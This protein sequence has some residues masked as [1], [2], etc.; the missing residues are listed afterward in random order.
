MANTIN[1]VYPYGIYNT[2]IHSNFQKAPVEPVEA[3]KKV[4]NTA[5]A[6]TSNRTYTQTFDETSRIFLNQYTNQYHQLQ[7][8]AD[9]LRQDSNNNIWRT[10]ASD[11]P[12]T[13]LYPLAAEQSYPAAV[14]VAQ[15][16]DKLVAAH[17]QTLTLLNEHSELG[18]GLARQIDQLRQ[19]VAS[20]ERM[21]SIGL[22]YQESGQ[23]SFDREAF[24]RAYVADQQQV[25]SLLGGNQGIAEAMAKNSADALNQPSQALTG[26]AA[27]SRTDSQSMQNRQNQLFQLT[28][29]L[30]RGG[31][32]AVSFSYLG[33]FIDTHA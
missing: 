26:A 23:L 27:D 28:G 12:R 33:R 30:A 3:A 19:P 29:S 5:T 24:S 20:A 18:F 17:N 10:S 11:T 7:T 8:A 32:G 14:T 4:N 31:F 15:T 1:G 6:H 13:N 2:L 21:S 25:K 22:S 16:V 9:N